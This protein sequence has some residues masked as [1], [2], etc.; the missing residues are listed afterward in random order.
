MARKFPQEVFLHIDDESVPIDEQ[1]FSI[2]EK[3]RERAQAAREI[4]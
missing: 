3:P 2:D 1:W 4:V